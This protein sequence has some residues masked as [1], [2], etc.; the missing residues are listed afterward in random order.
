MTELTCRDVA[1]FLLAYVDD[2]LDAAQRR[3]FEA[4]LS[5][6]D[7]CVRYLRDYA[8]AVRLG[9][10]AFAAEE[11]D[12]IPRELVSAILAARRMI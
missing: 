3:V 6:C 12:R 4:H 10:A 11:P 7:E 1:E 2:T 8:N 9:R 5:M